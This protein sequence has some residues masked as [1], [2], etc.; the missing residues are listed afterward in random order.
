MLVAVWHNEICTHKIKNNHFV[1][2]KMN[3]WNT[4]VEMLYLTE[5]KN[6]CEFR[7]MKDGHYFPN[8]PYNSE[9]YILNSNLILV[10]R[11]L[12]HNAKP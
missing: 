2:M 6:F 1:E 8:D 7:C 4:Y 11:Y 9:I 10:F 12:S 5:T 3:L